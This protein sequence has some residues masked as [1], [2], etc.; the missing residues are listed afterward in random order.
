MTIVASFMLFA[1]VYWEG[2]RVRGIF[3]NIDHRLRELH[4][5]L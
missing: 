3:P 2:V 4:V 5:K 1:I